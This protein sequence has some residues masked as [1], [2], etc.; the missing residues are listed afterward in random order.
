MFQSIPRCYSHASVCIMSWMQS[1]VVPPDRFRWLSGSMK[2]FAFRQFLRWGWRSLQEYHKWQLLDQ[3][4]I[5][6][7]HPPQNWRYNLWYSFWD[8]D[9]QIKAFLLKVHPWRSITQSN[10]DLETNTALI[11]STCSDQS[12]G[13]ATAIS[14]ETLGTN[15]RSVRRGWRYGQC[16]EDLTQVWFPRSQAL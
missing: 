8:M 4:V 2:Q 11:A 15:P 14:L 3:D 7:R 16:R 9:T 1:L 13:L 5:S 6:T 10:T 12:P